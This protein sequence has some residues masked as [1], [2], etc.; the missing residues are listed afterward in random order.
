VAT[1]T[2]RSA[3]VQRIRHVVETVFGA[4]TLIEIRPRTDRAVQ[5]ELFPLEPTTTNTDATATGRATRRR[6]RRP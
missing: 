4:T 3:A 2:S 6:P 1:L 5:D